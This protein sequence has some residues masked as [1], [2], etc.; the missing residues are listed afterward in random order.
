MPSALPCRSF[1]VELHADELNR[2]DCR[3][4]REQHRCLLHQGG[5]DRTREMRLP[6]RLVGERIEHAVGTWA[7]LQRKPEGR[8]TFLGGEL[9][10]CRQELLD[11]SLLSLLRLEANEQREFQ[12]RRSPCLSCDVD[13]T[14]RQVHA[15]EIRHL[16]HCVLLAELT[17][18]ISLSPCAFASSRSTT[19]SIPDWRRSS[20]P[21]RQPMS[22]RRSRH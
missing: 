2:L 20:T 21:S 1:H 9:E 12:H 6:A 10:S 18:L 16:L 4:R 14:T 3:R 7:K 11:G 22:S 5:R 8:S 19:C 13:P 17:F 15:L